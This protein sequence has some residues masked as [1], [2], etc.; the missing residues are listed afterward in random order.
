[1]ND[2]LSKPDLPDR[3]SC[4]PRSPNYVEEIF[5]HDIGIRL[6]GKERF[7][8]EEY[9]ISEGW[10]KIPSPK[11]LDRRGQPLLITLKGTVEAYYS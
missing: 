8:V 3:L 1:M 7:D 11:A 5:E 10:V 9:C 2:T 4:N 6:N